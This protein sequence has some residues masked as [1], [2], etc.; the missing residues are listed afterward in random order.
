[1]TLFT[2]NSMDDEAA[3]GLKAILCFKVPDQN[4]G[5]DWKFLFFFS[6]GLAKTA[7]GKKAYVSQNKKVKPED[8]D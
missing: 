4:S 5:K 2:L 7:V 8:V 6:A 1:M 3:P